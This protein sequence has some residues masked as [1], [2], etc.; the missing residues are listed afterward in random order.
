VHPRREENPTV[1][2]PETKVA[3][4]V[5]AAGAFGGV[6]SLMF[7]LV[8]QQPLGHALDN[9]AVIVLAMGAAPIGVYVIGNSD[10]REVMRCL[11]FAFLCG[12]AWRPVYEGGT[13]YVKTLAQQSGALRSAQQASQA[14][15][16][17]RGTTTATAGAAP[18]RVAAV[19]EAAVK[20]TST[21]PSAATDAAR[22]AVT[23]TNLHAVSALAGA[24][25]YQPSLT[26]QALAQIGVVAAQKGDSVSARQALVALDSIGSTARALPPV[27]R[28]LVL[29]NR[30]AVLRA[31]VLG[32]R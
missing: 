6:A 4:G 3:L 19:S 27:T 15:R 28:Q 13:V 5:V 17:L 20:A 18:A 9:A 30:Q 16:D 12:F 26:S 24:G 32:K 11:T 10:R 31:M 2:S 23:E 21:L 7:A 29:E 22:D 1:P 8:T 25:R 14:A